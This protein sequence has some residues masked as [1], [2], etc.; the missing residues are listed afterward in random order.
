[1]GRRGKEGGRGTLHHQGRA[2]WRRVNGKKNDRETGNEPDRFTVALLLPLVSDEG[3][4]RE[5]ANGSGV[6]L[7]R[8]PPPL[9]S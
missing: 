4:E 9:R 6:D 7:T 2:G 8:R 1:M 3:G 5:E